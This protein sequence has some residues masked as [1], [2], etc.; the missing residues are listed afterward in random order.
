MSSPDLDLTGSA[1]PAGYANSGDAVEEFERQRVP[2]SRLKGLRSFVGMYAGEHVAGTEF[3]IGPLFLA[4]GVSAFD[5]IVGLLVGNVLATLSWTWICAPIATR[6]RLTLYF[7]LESI[8][9]LRLVTLYNLANGVLFCFLA[10]AMIS[11]SATAV[12]VPLAMRMPGLDDWFPNSAAWV[13]VVLAIGAAFAYVAAKGYDSVVRVANLSVPWMVLV[14]VACGLVALPKLGVTS[15]GDFWQVA[16][17]RIWTG[18]DPMPGQTKFSFGHVVFFAWFCNAAMHMGMADLSIFRYARK[19]S[20]GLS[21]GAGMFVGHYMAWIA[22]SMLYA[23][24]LARDPSQT[25]VSP[26][27]MAYEAVGIAGLI[28]VILAGWTTANPTLYRSGLAF[29]AI[30][31]GSSRVAATLVAGAL[32]TGAAIFPAL[33]MKLLGF[34]GLYGTILMPMGAIVFVD[35]WLL[36]R[37]GLTSDYARRTRSSFNAAAG[38]AWLLALLICGMLNRWAGVQI[39]FLALPGW[40]LAGLLFLGLSWLLQSRHTPP[41]ARISNPKDAPVGSPHP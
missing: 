7:K 15:L 3:M 34:V 21:S 37:C 20:Y 31:P 38:L 8:C 16:Q 32:A 11:V 2:D 22:A 36:E 33:S 17:T 6:L 39:Y 18:G 14:F 28:C 24:Q 10:G 29:Q 13:V 9:G 35:F 30:V 19:T 41:G 1:S 4:S 23:V 25:A 12:G 27:P 40:I 5:L 26:G